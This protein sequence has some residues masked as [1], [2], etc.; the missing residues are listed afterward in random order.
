MSFRDR[1]RYD[2]RFGSMYNVSDE[3]PPLLSVIDAKKLENYLLN[4]FKYASKAKTKEI[5]LVM[6][7]TGSGKST[8]VNYLLGNEMIKSFSTLGETVF[9]TKLDN[10]S[11]PKI[12]HNESETLYSMLYKDE[13]TKLVYCDCPGFYDQRGDEEQICTEISMQLILKYAQSIKAVL[14][15]IDYNELYVTRGNGFISL[16][17]TLS[18]LFKTLDSVFNSILF[19]FT[20]VDQKNHITTCEMI[21]QHVYEKHEQLSRYSRKFESLCTNFDEIRDSE[22]NLEFLN[23]MYSNKHN[24]FIVDYE[25]AT[26]KNLI[27]NRIF[28]LN[29]TLETTNLNY[30]IDIRHQKL[31]DR[32]IDRIAY[33]GTRLIEK[34][35]EINKTISD[36]SNQRKQLGDRV[37][38]YKAELMLLDIKTTESE[39]FSGKTGDFSNKI[40][41][42]SSLYSNHSMTVSEFS[43]ESSS[44]ESHLEIKILNEKL[45]HNEALRDAQMKKLL[46]IVKQIEELTYEIKKNDTDEM[47]LYWNDSLYEKRFTISVLGKKICFGRTHKVFQYKDVPFEKHEFFKNNGNFEIKENNGAAGRFKAVYV[48]DKGVDAT[49]WVKLYVKNKNFPD[50]KRKLNDWQQRLSKYLDEK[51]KLDEDI[52]KLN[53]TIQQFQKRINDLKNA[54]LNNRIVKPQEQLKLEFENVLYNCKLKIEELDEEISKA[55]DLHRKT[56]NLIFEKKLLFDMLSEFANVLNLKTLVLDEFLKLKLEHIGVDGRLTDKSSINNCEILHHYLCPIKQDIMEGNYENCRIFVFFVFAA[57][58][59]FFF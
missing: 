3:L 44:T 48:S 5:I 54:T 56:D 39:I 51:K 50:V 52:C 7:N 47:L 36:F 35:I 26:A 23:L 33:E 40:S 29:E 59:F 25:N 2:S 9:T 42:S 11:F 38:F 30:E 20:K 45:Q 10:S 14:I 43:I 41:R 12:G 16:N 31:I 15:V 1:D 37:T 34:L 28:E 55:R 53:E 46:P 21:A 58:L 17:K 4:S 6:G 24:F 13:A 57:F 22:K 27:T 19:I 49:A 32:L 8:V 18:K